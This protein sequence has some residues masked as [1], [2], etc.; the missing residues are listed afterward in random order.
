LDGCS[1]IW[2]SAGLTDRVIE[3][4]MRC[5]H[6]LN[7]EV[8]RHPAWNILKQF[9]RG[10]ASKTSC[11]C[12]VHAM[13]WSASTAISFCW[14]RIAFWDFFNMTQCGTIWNNIEQYKQY[15]SISECSGSSRAVRQSI[16]LLSS[17]HS[18]YQY[19]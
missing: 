3:C 6:E 14:S 9:N 4:E 8:M 19:N 7:R 5:S 17:I 18:I 2:G 1:C 12:N 15:C 13:P 10:L 11:E 16:L